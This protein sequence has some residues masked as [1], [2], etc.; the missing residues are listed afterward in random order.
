MMIVMVFEGCLFHEIISTLLVCFEINKILQTG[1]EYINILFVT[2]MFQFFPSAGCRLSLSCPNFSIAKPSSVCTGWCHQDCDG[3]F[4]VEVRK[5]FIGNSNA[6]KP[7]A[8]VVI[9]IIGN[10]YFG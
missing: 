8:N 5:D 1:N 7:S 6:Q 9:L 3:D 4:D 2:E 10:V